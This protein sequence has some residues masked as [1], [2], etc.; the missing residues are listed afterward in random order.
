MSE[1]LVTAGVVAMIGA[2]V[3]GGLKMAGAELPSIVGS[4]G[5]QVLLG[6]LG[7][8]L[9]MLGLNL[10]SLTGEGSPDPSPAPPSVPGIEGGLPATG[11]PP[12]SPRDPEDRVFVEGCVVTISNPLVSMHEEPD[13]FSQE[14][15]R[16]PAGDYG[17]LESA[18]VERLGPSQRWFRI[19][20]DSRSGWIPDDSFTVDGKSPQCP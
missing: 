9:L 1:F 18:D 3:G 6:L 15:V 16:V 13:R 2:V 4:K 19:Q 20:V 7:L 11:A 14:V 17:V 5:R 10:D 8:A 12:A